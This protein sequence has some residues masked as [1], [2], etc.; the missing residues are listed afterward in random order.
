MNV[1]KRGFVLFSDFSRSTS[2][3][4]ASLRCPAGTNST[5]PRYR[6]VSKTFSLGINNA[7]KR[8]C[9]SKLC[10]KQVC[11]AASER[12]TS[13]KSWSKP[14][15]WRCYC[16]RLLLLLQART[17]LPLLC[18]DLRHSDPLSDREGNEG[19]R[20]PIFLLWRRCLHSECR[21][22]HVRSH[23]CLFGACCCCC[24][25]VGR[26]YCSHDICSARWLRCCR[27]C[28]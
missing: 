2:A 3:T 6:T 20:G 14:S 15:C 8:F 13:C 5:K 25:A 1:E 11:A 28:K 16:P 21:S 24:C 10:W 9:T 26:S 19:E 23:V 27:C 18:R 7:S 17:P 22:V 4:A 12:Y